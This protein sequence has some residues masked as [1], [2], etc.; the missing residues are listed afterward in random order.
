MELLFR[1][2]SRR[3]PKVSTSKSKVMVLNEE[4]RL[5]C[6]ACVDEM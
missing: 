1:C 2:V 6:E 5:D 4:D 3:G